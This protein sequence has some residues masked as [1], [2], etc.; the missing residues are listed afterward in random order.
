M[1]IGDE[2][3]KEERTTKPITASPEHTGQAVL[4]ESSW[5]SRS[6]NS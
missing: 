3:E 6:L 5:T 4:S 2:P 1:V